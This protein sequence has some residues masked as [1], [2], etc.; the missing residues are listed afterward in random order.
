M[1]KV[2]KQHHKRLLWSI[3]LGLGIILSGTQH[4]YATHAAGS[5]IKY[6]CLGGLQ[7][8][9][10]VTFYR[11]CG[12]V[13][14]PATI[15]VN[16]KSANANV[17]LNATA[18]KIA[19]TGQEIT[20][21][22][23]ASSSTCGGG[24][25]TGIRK[26]VYT[27]T[28]TLPS[29]RAD[30]VFSYS[31]C[32]RNCAITTISNPCAS[33]SVL[34]V[35]ATLNNILA[36]C[37][38]SPTFSNIPI[39]FVCLGQNFNYN[40][41][42]IDP[43]GDSLAYQL[44][45]PKISNTT[46]VSFIAPAS[47]TTPIAS[48]TPFTMNAIT[49]D[50]NFT[51][52]AVQIGVMA[53]LVK[54]Y[55]NHQLIGTAIRDMQIYTTACSN[56]LPTAS[57]INGTSNFNTTVCPNQ[58]VC[59]TINTADLDAAQIVSITT[60]N[61]I[62]NATYTISSGNRPTLTFCWTPTF[63][64]IGLSPN[65]FTIT[66]RD[67]A[68]PNNGIQTYSYN[69]Y[70]PSPYFTATSTNVTCN[71][72][73]TGTASAIPVYAG[74]YL[75]NWNTTPPSTTATISNVVAG[76]YTVTVTD[77]GGCTALQTVNI[78]QPTG[79]T[80]STNI[81]NATCPGI[82]NGSID[83]SLSGGIAPYTYL[84]SNAQTNQDL[85]NLC[86][87]T[88][89]V[90][91]TDANNCTKTASYTITNLFTLSSSA[92]ASS[93]A[94]FGAN[95]GGIYTTISGGTTPY[96][97]AWSNGSSSQNLTN[98][99]AGTFT[100]TITDANLCKST[101][102]AQIT[103]PTASLAVSLSKMDVK[104]FGNTTG[105]ASSTVTGG[106]S[107]YTYTWSNGATTSS[108]TNITSGT[109]ILTVTDSHNCTTT[110]TTTITQ[111]LAVLAN[112][113]TKTDVLCFGNSTG[114][115][116]SSVTG[117][118]APYSY[119]WN[120]GAT[121]S[122]LN[123]I[124]AGTYTVTIT[125][126]NLC[127]TTTSISINQPAT[128]LS[129]NVVATY[130][131][132][133]GTSTGSVNLTVNGGTTP[134]T[135]NWSNGTSTQNISNVIAGTYTV[136]VTDANNC[137]ITKQATVTQPAVALSATNSNTNVQCNGD[138]TGA[139]NL[140]VSGGTSG[141][142]FL[143]NNGATSQNL[144]SLNA[145]SYNVTITDTRGCTFALS[146]VITQPT[147]ALNISTTKTDI[148]CYGTST[149]VA[150]VSASGGI[151]NYTY[152]WSNSATTSMINNIVAG[153]YTVTVTDA[154]NCSAIAMVTLTQ[155]AAGL[156]ATT[157]SINVK[158]K[159]NNTGSATIN[160]S[161]GTLPYTYL[162]SNG[163]GTSI[164]LNLVAGN[165]SVTVTDN[166]G[167]TINNSYA[168]TQPALQLQSSIVGTNVNCFGQ[169]KGNANL[170]V[171]GGTTPYLYSWSN[172][173]TTQNL[174]TIPSGNYT[175]TVTD[176][177]NCTSTTDII[178]SQPLAALNFSATGTDINCYNGTDGTITTSVSGG[179][180]PYSYN[181]NNSTTNSSLSSITAGTYTVTVTDNNSCTASQVVTLNQPSLALSL[182]TTHQNVTCNGLPAGSI[183]LTVNG[184]TTPYSY[185][186]NIG[187][188]QQDVTNLTAGTY[189]VTVTDSNGCTAI[190]SES[191]SQPPG[192]LNASSYITNASCYND[193]N[194]AIDLTA[195]AGTPPYS[196][197]WSN[198]VNTQDLNNLTAGTYTVTISDNNACAIAYTLF[199]TQ[200]SEILSTSFTTT[201]LT[202]FENNTGAID[203]TVNG[204]TLP[205]TFSWSNNSTTEDLTSLAAGN[206]TVNITDANECTT[207]G[208]A[209]VTQ[210]IG[211]LNISSIIQ[212]INCH[213]V[214]D[215]SINLTINGGT[216]P[217]TFL[218][219]D[220]NTT[221]DLSGLSIGTYTVTV[222]D[223]NGCYTSKSFTITYN[224]S[225]LTSSASITE[226]TC[227]GASTGAI[228]LD[229]QGGTTP[230]TYSWSN[231]STSQD[232]LNITTGVYTVEITDVNGCTTSLS[233]SINEPAASISITQTVNP[234]LCH[235]N[236]TGAI[237]VTVQGGTF[238]YI[239]SWNNGETQED[240]LGMTAG[241]YTLTITDSKNCTLVQ[242]MV[243]DEP[244]AVLNATFQTTNPACY[245]ELTGNIA[246]TISGGTPIYSI[247][248]N[249]QPSQADLN[250]IA[251][252]SYS[253][254]ITDANGC[255][256]SQTIIVDQP[257]AILNTQSQITHVDCNGNGTGSISL[258]P[259]G[260]TSPYSYQWSNGNTTAIAN[261]LVIGNY[262][263]TITDSHQCIINGSANIWQ[264]Q[265]AISLTN[266]NTNVNCYG[267]SSATIDLTVSGGTIP[268][269]FNWSNSITTEDLSNLN[270]GDYTVTVTD[271]NGCI[272]IQTFTIS[273]PASALSATG[274]VTNL[275]CYS[276]NS[277]SINTTT[278][279]GT[280]P[281]I[282]SWTNGET[283][284]S[285]S[286]LSA[287]TYAVL[288]SDANGCTF[289]SS[290]TVTQPTAQLSATATTTNVTCNGNNN[291]TISLITSGGTFPYT[292][293]WSNGNTTSNPQNLIS[294]LYTVTITDANNCIYVY[295][296]NVQQP[297]AVLD[298]TYFVTDV[299][300]FGNST[301]AI[302]AL[303][304]GGTNPYTYLWSDGT[305]SSSIQNLAAGIYTLTVT[306]VNN[307][308]KT[309]PVSVSQPIAPI[310]ANAQSYQVN[311]YNALNG[312]IDLIVSGGMGN[313]SYQWNNGDTLQNLTNLLSGIY[314]V[315]IT[316]QNG[317]TASASTTITQPGTNLIISATVNNVNCKG[318]GNGSIELTV[319]GGTPS[320]T[321]LWSNGNTT[322]LLNAVS[323]GS[324]SVTVTDAHGCS[325][326]YSTTIQEPGNQLAITA[327][328]KAANCIS[329]IK[330]N[331]YIQVNGGTSPYSFVWN[332]GQTAQ[333]RLNEIPG[334]YTVTVTDGNGCNDAKTA[335]IA[336]TSVLAIESKG[337]ANICMGDKAILIADS[338]PGVTLQWNYNGV[339]LNGATSNSF[340]TPVAGSYTLTAT[341]SCGTY[342]S[343]SIDVIV[344]TMNSVS[345]NNN[346]IICKGE[347]IQLVAGGGIDYQW[348]PSLGLNF[349]NIPNPT[350]S[351]EKT[352]EYIVTVKDQY[353]CKATAAVTITLGCDTLDIPNGFSPNGDGTNDYFVIDGINNYPGN[354][355]FI[356]NRW[357][358]L[359]YKQ[360]DYDN[361][362]NGSSNV[363][364]ALFGEE[365]PNGTY[366]FILNLNNEQKPINGFVVI[367]R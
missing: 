144:N 157:S 223:T 105:S 220:G 153:T 75:Y 239:Y 77:G 342:T 201:A 63:A 106:T 43:D 119:N 269:N 10:E 268:Y 327:N 260:G 68:C 250:S 132:C 319:S 279:G 103:Q 246:T 263:Y 97:Y 347:K 304:N 285:I 120:N 301:G 28:I 199:V 320:Y 87:G 339:P 32:C 135:Y 354:S 118:T 341:S 229:V 289:T 349:D 1:K 236:S 213:D 145:G 338:M 186:W 271:A 159:D 267:S 96:T 351:P 170:T 134:Y 56:N 294:G 113:T 26:F 38:S 115:I 123:N 98:T 238:P 40:H 82:C 174:N 218:W 329:N 14:E 257:L 234:V 100:L 6:R 90:T 343:N 93:V 364:G 182:S 321:Y 274:N 360:H 266:T 57:G 163:N 181:W 109:Y 25:T 300:C 216:A 225:T 83:L 202:C 166:N 154:N 316:D 108:L 81:I 305:T 287:G 298:I 139:V 39:A 297:S 345:I 306:D 180:S 127:T 322:S 178:I 155:P 137:S 358:N 149:G 27:A 196:Y 194:G 315:I 232:L 325:L 35:E 95:T 264:P 357:G 107:P 156:S 323:S 176:A 167:C 158:C 258:Q 175:V 66:V 290:Y 169:S 2:M 203:L 4:V 179:T 335:A 61:G 13:A 54:E 280:A 84:W 22:C 126:A 183:D 9:V 333:N 21:P 161:G 114:T 190:T 253:I 307:C 292:Y 101:V 76:T 46:N 94:C 363:G 111:P 33:S 302:S 308:I 350:A 189:T 150:S 191:I 112:S 172:G 337:D 198:G 124:V 162:W 117:G 353:G 295:T 255:V 23:T 275:S 72:S 85:N 18:N 222:T 367:R 131:N 361:K 328:A 99:I 286:S 273:Q 215:A 230:Y 281:Y 52:S 330:G 221:E 326:Q 133:Y 8:E 141:Y 265:A 317:C 352:T 362:W 228:D 146:T 318:S 86:L 205:Y 241:V 116:S 227:H 365:L 164:N 29:A 173:N 55:R 140:T 165:Y 344:R 334:T 303:V 237:D 200:P 102:S 78:T 313:Y 50:L 143:W 177:N 233:G 299:K 272:S 34:Y 324:F 168:I 152:N 11:D 226:V 231:N 19:S 336:D 282:Y 259:N 44:V 31:V 248:W 197:S 309:M 92:T 210:P 240:L 284:S 5:D 64:D 348:S 53:I 366:Y 219:N 151:G 51:P 296:Q 67:N 283:T 89:T 30:W 104:C 36:P 184:G 148:R 160:I 187:S 129:G 208:S 80:L 262:Q 314:S 122:S 192:A 60:N 71:G 261:G 331:I 17:N 247:L 270:A 142:T 244:T 3:L 69:I 278:N 15:T 332:D 206:Y 312:K 110:A 249:N 45:A 245:G 65:T 207:S 24:S 70:V 340:V 88:Y 37:N 138:N 7:Y 79:I 251:A 136:T 171:I 48:S 356:Y 185:L 195:T 311:C 235:G 16:Y 288:V 188:P 130:A 277:G 12:G 211:A 291:G 217:Y 224:A 58:Q 346:V 243:I 20:V 193:N 91:V 42:V 254:E 209:T 212:N 310:S 276:N 62:P 355:I 49:G 252:G 47:V 293:N 41:G 128:T 214:N 121:S 147:A 73:S 256:L 59:F 204:G 359:I 125:D 74:T 242:S